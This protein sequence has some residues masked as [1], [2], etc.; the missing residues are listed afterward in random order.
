MRAFFVGTG[1]VVLLL[2][3]WVVGVEA[4]GPPT[5][6]R[7]ETRLITKFGEPKLQMVTVPQPVVS[8]VVNDKTKIVRI[9][10]VGPTRVVVI[11]SGGQQ[12]VAYLPVDQ[13]P[14][15]TAA[16]VDT[17]LTVYVPQEPVTIT[18]TV[19]ETVTETATETQTATETVTETAPP[20]SDAS[21]TDAPSSP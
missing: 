7:V 18:E 3:G 13:V 2:G 10:G 8:T 16:A 11:H 1:L 5:P 21:S 20:T 12:L 17:P 6:A 15:L 14:A 4:G 19:S 9:E